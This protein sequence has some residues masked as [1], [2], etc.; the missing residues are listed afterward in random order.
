[1]KRE[2][3]QI[4]DGRTVTPHQH[5]ADV[6]MLEG[7]RVTVAIH[8]DEVS[9]VDEVGRE[10]H[11]GPVRSRNRRPNEAARGDAAARFVTLNTFVDQVMRRLS[12]VESLVWIVAF[13]D[14][15]N[16]QS[17]TSSQD[18]ATRTGCSLRAVK[19]AVKALC[20]AG[21]MTPVTL[22]RHKGTASIYAVTTQPHLC[23]S[24]LPVR[25]RRQRPATG[26][27]VA[28]VGSDAT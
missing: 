11:R 13:R 28:P 16:G 21:L 22:S 9:V 24:K 19:T 17:S 8:G 6:W 26:A 5:H 2:S 10:V 20:K 4:S 18:L 27:S 25:P 12:P 15:R 7:N 3:F 23:V 14:C 1:M